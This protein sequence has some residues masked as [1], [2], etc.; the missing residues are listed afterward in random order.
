MRFLQM[1]DSLS[2]LGIETNWLLYQ[3]L[4]SQKEMHFLSPT[5]GYEHEKAKGKRDVA[6]HEKGTEFVIFFEEIL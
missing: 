2:L 3:F 5:S 1:H 4:S 6:K